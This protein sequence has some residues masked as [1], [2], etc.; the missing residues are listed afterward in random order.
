MLK[1]IPGE[2]ASG[3]LSVK[4][5]EK[6]ILKKQTKKTHLAYGEMYWF[7]LSF[8]PCLLAWGH[9]K[10]KNWE[11]YVKGDTRWISFKWHILIKVELKKQKKNTWLFFYLLFIG[12]DL[13]SGGKSDILKS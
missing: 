13:Q 5:G 11:I 4:S 2:L 6:K 9:I 8:L 12:V 3:D 7:M 1:G 10:I